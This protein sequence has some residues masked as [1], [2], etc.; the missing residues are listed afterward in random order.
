MYCCAPDWS[1]DWISE[2]DLTSILE[3]VSGRIKPSPYG[4]ER[5]GLNYGLHFTG[6]EPFMNFDLLLRSVDIASQLRIPSTFVETNCFWCTSD[7]DTRDRLE[8]LKDKGLRGILASVN[9]FYL[10]YVPFERTERAIRLSR[11]VFGP[12]V[13]VYQ[14]EYYSQF[15]QLGI[16]GTLTLDQYLQMVNLEQMRRSVELFLTGRAAYALESFY[17]HHPADHFTTGRCQPPFLR[18]W[19]NHVDNY[20]NYVPG[21]CGGISL[22]D[23]R[24]LDLLCTDGIDA[25]SHPVLT[26]LADEDMAGLLAFATNEYAYKERPEGYV[27]RCHLCVDVRRHLAE[28]GFEELRPKEFYRHLEY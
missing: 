19:H 17:P 7:A 5:V 10:E 2:A 21:Y 16:R 8:L 27:S 22:G 20:G 24:N 18:E 14:A 11:Q 1:A 23:A 26:F 15:R 3:Q 12:N 28:E 6:G 4:A 9:P 13:M 25:E